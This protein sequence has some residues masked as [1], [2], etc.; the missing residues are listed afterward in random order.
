MTTEAAIRWL[1]ALTLVFETPGLAFAQPASSPQGNPTPAAT[2]DDLWRRGREAMNR[3]DFKAALE[4]LRA[5][6]KLEPGHGKVVNI[7]VCE[8]E[9]GRI[10]AAL[11]L[12]EEVLPHLQASDP[13]VPLINEHLAALRPRVPQLV[14]AGA[15]EVTVVKLDGHVVPRARLGTPMRV[16]PGTHVVT[17][18]GLGMETARYQLKLGEREQKTVRVALERIAA[19]P[20]PA[21]ADSTLWRLGLTAAGVGGAALLAGAGT[22]I[23]AVVVRGSVSEQCPN[24]V[25]SPAPSDDPEKA[26]ADLRSK[27]SLYNAL[28]NTSTAT[29]IA[30]GV[31]AATG[32]TL[33]VVSKRKPRSSGW[34]EPM[35][36]VGMVG[37]EGRF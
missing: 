9:L 25:C 24:G 2:A 23:G 13:R 14:I 1:L 18:T 27:I 8:E 7:A 15:A 21:K 10:G 11:G 4:L 16:D 20:P 34:I 29:L 31:L 32:A 36:G 30:G 33:L 19:A 22:G 35:V 28:G 12:F 3:R 5:S 17:A 6:H 26:R 37:A